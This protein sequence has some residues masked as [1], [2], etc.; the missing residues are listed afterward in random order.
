[1]VDDYIAR[2]LKRL[3]GDSEPSSTLE[4]LSR[5]Q[6]WDL[7]I[8]ALEIAYE[9]GKSDAEKDGYLQSLQATS[10]IAR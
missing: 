7:V 4:S 9:H 1:M 2:E 10:P 5:V 3:T 8:S 6:G